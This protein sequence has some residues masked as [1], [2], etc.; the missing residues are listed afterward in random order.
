MGIDVNSAGLL[1]TAKARGV[2]FGRVL[3]LGRQELNVSATTL[4]HLLRPFGGELP[5]PAE[6]TGFAE[7]LFR[8]LGASEV[9]ALDASGYEQATIKHDLNLPIPEIWRNAF[10]VVYDGGTLEHVFN[11]P[12]AL[13]NAMEMVHVGGRLFLHQAINNWCGHGFY[14]FSPELFFRALSV[15]NGY[16]IERVVVHSVSPFARWY[17]VSDPATLQARVELLSWLPIM[18]FVQAQRI[19]ETPIFSRMPQQSDYTIAWTTSHSQPPAAS[20]RFAWLEWCPPLA[21]L[22]RALQTM[23]RFTRTHT[24]SNRAAFHPVSKS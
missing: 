14:Q 2:V 22:A 20:R 16:K 1:A 3:M 5:Q 4:T 17:E 7:P 18:I 24:L 6:W 13:R 21:A 11:F 12:V 8:A 15:E 10:D 19:A 23:W 9:H